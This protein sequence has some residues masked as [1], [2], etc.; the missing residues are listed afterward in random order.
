MPLASASL[1]INFR[2]YQQ[3][4]LAVF[5]SQRSKGDRKF[6]FV[7]PPGAGK[8]LIGLELIIRLQ[9]PAVVFS[10]T[11]AIQA[12]W[13]TLG[14]QYTDSLTFSTDPASTANV[15]SLTYQIVSSKSQDTGELHKNAQNYLRLLAERR[16]VILDECHHLTDYWAEIITRLDKAGV[17]LIGLT[18]TPPSDR[19]KKE[20]SIYFNLLDA[21]DYEILLPPVVKE[22]YLAPY[23]DLVY[24]VSPTDK[25]VEIIQN[26]CTRYQAIMEKLFTTS[27]VIPI[28]HWAASRLE[29]Y[30]DEKKLPIPF[31]ELF[32]QKPEF[33]I[34]CARLLLKRKVELPYSVHFC[35]EMEE[36]LTFPDMLSVIEDY[37]LYYMENEPLG[38][39]YLKEL[40]AALK[41]I[42]YLLTGDGMQSLPYGIKSILGMSQSKV[43]ALKAIITREM[44]AQGE[45][46]RCLILTDYEQ[47]KEL[48]GTSALEVMDFLTRDAE[49]DKCNPILLTGATVLVDDDLLPDFLVC[50]EIF[51]E[52]ENLSIKLIH[53]L[54][55][56][57][58]GIT[59][60]S[61]QWNTHTYVTLI[62]YLLERGI[63]KC[64]VSTRS[65]LGE[66]WNSI[67]LNTLVDLT[68]VASYAFVN[69]IRGRTVRLDEERPFKTANNWDIVTI[70]PD[71]EQGLYDFERL[72]KKFTRFYGLSADG[73]VERGLGH[74]HP[75]LS[76]GRV[77]I[78]YNQKEEINREMFA[79]ADD[80]LAAYKK[81]HVGRPYQN[82][83]I[84][85]LE[86][87]D[88]EK[89]ATAYPGFGGVTEKMLHKRLKTAQK[90]K[91]GLDLV[92]TAGSL[93][94]GAALFFHVVAAAITVPAAFGMLLVGFA[95]VQM[96]RK[97]L[98]P[99]V[100][101]LIPYS[102][103]RLKRT[104]QRQSSLE[105]LLLTLGRIIVAT[106]NELGL[107]PN[108]LMTKDI[109]LARREDGSYRI[110]SNS[111][112]ISSLLCSTL[113]D[114]FAPLQQQKYFIEYTPFT[115]AGADA[116]YK[117]F[118]LTFKMKKFTP[119]E[120]QA[121]YRRA[122]KELTQVDSG[123]RENFYET[124]YF[125]V[126]E[127]FSKTNA[128]ARVFLKNWREVLAPAELIGSRSAAGKTV[129]NAHFR[130][131][132]LPLLQRKKDLWC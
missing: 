106:A 26:C 38:Q 88:A 110:Y 100:P 33:C 109:S 84:H 124:V 41:D 64:L 103:H 61:S 11:H 125:P 19:T 131:K 53:T 12:Q 42:G 10:P 129:L 47:G 132:A 28:Q 92:I 52:Q 17:Y 58:Y 27:E 116:L 86:I 122:R 87:Y 21:V 82:Q 83:I 9:K 14:R 3:D 51:F 70:F 74:V 119:R 94:G 117:K 31:D 4:M 102:T 29:N 98:V 97:Q 123:S 105:Q 89:T 85:C 40:Q 76:S 5:E 8:T 80:R 95:L 115:I 81:W 111:S 63:T 49:T 16:T 15:L 75:A 113:A 57:Y 18:A 79:R 43:L 127:L 54:I 35:Q 67:K 36:P 13:I 34:A 7:A 77:D 55:G 20:Q 62:T 126:P 107:Y 128:D 48:D 78:I 72:M 118:M 112:T 46:F 90:L 120:F 25:E 121:W 2:K 39:P 65:M 6:H 45:D 93:G 68:I 114:L 71:P 60:D 32:L 108:E 59:S 73:I 101:R 30:L 69:Q 37:V 24:L 66:G 22:G 91:R 99:F 130:K 96:G 23:Q 56:G 50:A 44:I 1:F 104:I